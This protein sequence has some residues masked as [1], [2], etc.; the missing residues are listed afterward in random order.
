MKSFLLSS[1]IFV[2]FI[3][4]SVESLPQWVTQI[5]GTTNN[6]RGV[7]FSDANNGTAVGQL[8][9]ILRTTDG[10]ANWVQQ[11]SGTTNELRCVSFTDADNGTVVGQFGTILR[12][13]DG[14]ANWVEQN[15]GVSTV[16]LERVSFIDADNG[17]VVGQNG[18][19]LKTTNGGTSWVEQTSDT[20]IYLRNVC[21]IDANYGFIVG[22]SGTILKTTNGG[23]NWVEQTSGITN[24]LIGVSFTG[25]STGTVVGVDG[26]ILRT[27]DG[28]TNWVEQTSGTPQWLLG[29]SFTDSNFGDAVGTG[30]ANI[31][32]TD[33][34]ATWT[35]QT[36]A[37][38]VLYDVSFTDNNTGTVVGENGTILRMS[39]TVPVE[40][41]SFTGSVEGT[42]VRLSWVTSSQLNNKGFEVE[43][44]QGSESYR[45]LTFIKGDGTTTEQKSYSYTDKGLKEGDYTYRLKQI[46]FD[47]SFHYSNEVNV[48]VNQP[49]E[50]SLSQNYPNPFN[51][52]TTINFSLAQKASVKLVVYDILGKEVRT[53]VNSNEAAGTYQVQ[54]NGLNNNGQSVS[55][56]IYIY[57]ITA[58]DFVQ[59]KKLMFMK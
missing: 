25:E 54:W 41:V 35:Q 37:T 57:R 36:N 11:T 1:Q 26:I 2:L 15:S 3:L 48:S 13:T 44:K 38:V 32:T 56:G 43:R 29:V 42:S 20:T 27:T 9:T 59:Q 33:G 52:S 6:L 23:T 34:G 46:D 17:L 49:A 19:I 50:F 55:T 4:F 21:F 16:W 58:G 47:A 30:G 18:T 39:T 7:S 45:A 28:G 8:G 14:G 24:N 51:P 31:R 40:L 53:L 22:Q 5:S 12:T 10:G